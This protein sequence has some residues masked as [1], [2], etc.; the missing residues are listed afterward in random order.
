MNIYVLPIV[1]PI[2]CGVMNKLKTYCNFFYKQHVYEELCFLILTKLHSGQILGKNI[3]KATKQ[4]PHTLWDYVVILCNCTPK[5]FRHYLNNALII[6]FSI[7]YY[8]ELCKGIFKLATW[9]HHEV[10]W[11]AKFWFFIAHMKMSKV[12]T[13]LPLSLHC[14][15]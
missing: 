2:E 11:P 14:C 8:L 1:F 4:H 10:T 3:R 5:I 12:S 9:M 13:M 15:L 7:T 6:V